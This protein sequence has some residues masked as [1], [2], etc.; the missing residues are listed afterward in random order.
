VSAGYVL[1]QSLGGGA[2]LATAFQAMS[3]ALHYAT[4][5]NYG[6]VAQ[7]AIKSV[8]SLVN[9]VQTNYASSF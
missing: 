4:D 3:N 6:T 8:S 5:P 7:A 9:C 1:G 2:S